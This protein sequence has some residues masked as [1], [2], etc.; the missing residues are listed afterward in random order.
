[1]ASSL[2]T[3]VEGSVFS[4]S[5]VHETNINDTAATIDKYIFLFRS[6]L[7]EIH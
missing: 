7:K 4:Q 2:G 3:A 6:N 1:M 5:A